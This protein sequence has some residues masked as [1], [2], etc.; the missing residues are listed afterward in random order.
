VSLRGLV[1]LVLLLAAAVGALMYLDRKG[2]PH[3]AA[4]PEAPL[5]PAFTEESLREIELSCQDGNVT[6]RRE[7]PA[8][9]MLAEPFAAEADPR[10]V[11]ELIAA[12]ED[13]R[14]R[15]VIAEG[16]AP[17][18]SFGLEP[19]ACTV[20]LAFTAKAEGL[21]LRLGR[22]SPVG[23]ERYAAGDDGR[24]V[25]ADG[26]L[27]A[28]VSRGAGALRERRLFPLDAESVTRIELDRPDGRVVLARRDGSWRIEAPFSDAAS[29]SACASLA[30]AVTSFAV[31]EPAAGAA[32]SYVR[33]ERRIRIAITAQGAAGAAA[34]IEGKRLGWREGGRLTGLVDEASAVALTKPPDSFRESRIAS[35]ASPDVRSVSIVRGAT[36]LVV[37]RSGEAKP[38][39]GVDGS[40]AVP[41]D[42]ARVDGLLDRLRGLDASGFLA[43]PP[44]SATTGTIAVAGEKGEL[45]RLTYGPLPGTAGSEGPSSW[46]TTPA[47][48]GVVFN[49]S[50][51]S[52]G[53]VPASAADL[54]PVASPK[55]AG[56]G[57]S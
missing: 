42:G 54:A 52:L 9:W 4:S 47:R 39:S 33:P 51:A 18:A 5:L 10:R 16:K 49:V 53:R 30:R 26:S 12:L 24:V 50:T 45:L 27:Y 6:V 2:A 15:K 22:A 13:A 38:W 40:T 29:S 19:A 37:S 46:V 7:A 20:H 28:V 43:A 21:T 57:G 14:I 32:P 8:G 17:L 31:T 34:G 23:T 11:H 25:F 56:S 48:P 35:F 44:A 55:T 1:A 3:E 36:H 41:V